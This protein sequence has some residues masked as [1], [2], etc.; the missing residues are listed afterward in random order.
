MISSVVNATEETEALKH[1]G[2]AS[3]KYFQLDRYV[4]K[5]EKRHLSNDVR[6]YGGWVSTGIRIAVDKKITY[7]WSF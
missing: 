3:Y 4:R 5:M 1:V 2:K 6:K 7:T